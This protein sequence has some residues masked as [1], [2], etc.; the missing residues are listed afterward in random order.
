MNASRILPYITA[1]TALAVSV[2]MIVVAG[3]R[4]TGLA[5]VL[6][7]VVIGIALVLVPVLLIGI[8]RLSGRREVE[9]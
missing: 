8:A 3:A 7:G 5:A 9:R 1:A 2:A 6:T 4:S